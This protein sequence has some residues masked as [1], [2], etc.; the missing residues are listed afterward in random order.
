MTTRAWRAYAFDMG[1]IRCSSCGKSEWTNKGVCSCGNPHARVDFY[2]KKT[3]YYFTDQDGGRL[4][5]QTARALLGVIQTELDNCRKRGM[6]FD[7]YKWKQQEKKTIGKVLD[8]YLVH[9][10]TALSKGRLHPGSL[11]TIESHIR[12]YIRPFF[13]ELSDG[14]FTRPVIFRFLD[15][16]PISLKRNTKANI[17]GVLKAFIHWA[18]YPII[19]PNF[20]CDDDA[21]PRISLSLTEQMEALERLPKE[22]RDIIEFLMETGLRPAE[23][24]VIKTMDITPKGTM[25]V[26]ST[27]SGNVE[28]NSTKAGTR[29]E[30]AL[31]DRALEIARENAGDV[32]LFIN[33]N[34]GQR[35]T[36]HYLRTM[37]RKYSGVACTLYEA[38]RHSFISQIVDSGASVLQTKTVARHS[39]VKTT[40]RYYHGDRVTLKD[41]LDRRGKVIPLNSDAT[42]MRGK[43]HE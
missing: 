9:K 30:L 29:V 5:Y 38:T 27:M 6:T 18:G 21:E 39:D 28:I 8:A 37:W 31:S 12:N 16:L 2:F 33:H 41:L 32:Y 3:H 10:D 13:G 11:S 26:R 14:D 35:Y 24:V 19:C 20:E 36:T 25:W 42:L 40:Q 17:Y 15:S 1:Q 23:V 7:P 43:N 34:T 22:H 4:T